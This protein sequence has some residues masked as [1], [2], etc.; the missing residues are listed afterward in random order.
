MHIGFGQEHFDKEAHTDDEYCAN[1]KQFH[2]AD[3]QPLQI[4]QQERIAETDE[5]TPDQV[6]SE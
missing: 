4:Q 6:Q 3:A 2:F 5:Y 1:D